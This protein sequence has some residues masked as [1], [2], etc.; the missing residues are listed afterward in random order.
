[1]RCAPHQS[2][3]NFVPILRDDM[4]SELLEI[5]ARM[6]EEEALQKIT[7]TVWESV[8]TAT[9]QRLEQVAGDFGCQDG[10]EFLRLHLLAQ[11]Q[12][13]LSIDAWLETLPG[14]VY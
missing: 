12:Q 13:Y 1:L 9:R 11:R 8:T 10:F 4:P 6:T 5:Q 14:R 2:I 3:R 7:A